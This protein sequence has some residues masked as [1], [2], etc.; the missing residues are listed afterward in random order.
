MNLASLIA[1][2]PDA[3]PAILSANEVTTYGALRAQVAALRGG[4][5]ALGVEPDDRVGLMLASNWYFVAAYL[6]VLGSG[7]IAVPLNPQSPTAELSAEL[8]S[9]R[10]KVVVVG[11]T[12]ADAF[13]KVDRSCVGI[14]TVLVPHG[15]D[16]ADALSFEDLL[17]SEP[18]PIVDR[19]SDAPAVLLFTSGTAGAPKAAVLTHGNLLSNIAQAQAS[20]GNAV[21]ASDVVLGALPLFHVYG[22]NAV[23]GR[24]LAAGALTVLVQ[25]FDPASS[26]ATV[27]DRGVSL[28]AGVPLMFDAWVRLDD[29]EATRAVFATVRA[30][31]SGG[32]RLDPSVAAAFQKRFGVA[33]G[34]G[35]GLTEAAPIVTAALQPNPVPGTVGRPI[36]GVEVRIVDENGDD[37]VAGDAG[38]IWV[39]GPNVFP[40]YWND[41]EATA[42]ALTPEGWLRTGDIAVI[43]DDG[44]LTIVDRVKDLIIV[45]G[46]NVYPA[47][48]EEVLA[49]HPGVAEVAVVGVPHPHTG[50]SVKA[51]VVAKPDRALEEDEVIAYCGTYLARYKCPSKVLFVRDLPHG[52]AGKILRRELKV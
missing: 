6:A 16:L 39:R 33:I 26:V 46:F 27:R 36:P 22:L 13:A 19:P 8:A 49:G 30:A 41:A 25:R 2:H 7:A 42:R 44:E 12:A 17:V 34:E 47:E 9:V 23:L 15:V 35:Y 11:P 20:S 3:A 4:L 18:A 28:I 40:G 21:V 10:P 50:E 52:V 1:A 37:T 51:F 5:A 43:D 48:V 14:A 31:A 24:A 32:A 29:G 45:S 38:E